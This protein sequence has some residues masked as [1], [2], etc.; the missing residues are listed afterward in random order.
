MRKINIWMQLWGHPTPKR[1]SLLSNSCQ[2]H[3]LQTGK[4]VRG[5]PLLQTCR[6]YTD[7]AGVVRFQGTSALKSTQLLVHPKVRT[8]PEVCRVVGSFVLPV[9]FQKR[10]S[11]NLTMSFGALAYKAVSTSLRSCCHHDGHWRSL[12]T[13][14]GVGRGFSSV[15]GAPKR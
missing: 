12:R 1:T 15:I 14:S 11:P 8:T 2:L 4:L 13:Q 5:K 6:K 10:I 7:S 3:T 9:H